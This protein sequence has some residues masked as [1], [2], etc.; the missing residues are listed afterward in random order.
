M[1]GLRV[2]MEMENKPKGGFPAKMKNYFLNV[3][4]FLEKCIKITSI[5][6]HGEYA[7]LLQKHLG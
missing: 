2:K 1:V 5:Q 7:F 6:G 4:L 3:F